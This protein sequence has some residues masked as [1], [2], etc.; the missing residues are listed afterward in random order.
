MFVIIPCKKSYSGKLFA[1]V[2]GAFSVSGACTASDGDDANSLLNRALVGVDTDSGIGFHDS[3]SA[4][5][6]DT[7]ANHYRRIETVCL[8]IEIDGLS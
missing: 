3:A 5:D 7:S 6:G 4:T 2:S 8:L 1:G